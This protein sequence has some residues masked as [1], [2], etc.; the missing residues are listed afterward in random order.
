MNK[1]LY[2][3]SFLMAIL[4]ISVLPS[5]VLAVSTLT[6]NTNKQIYYAGDKLI[7]FGYTDANETLTAEVI[8][9]SGDIIAAE[10]TTADASG[11]YNMSIFAFPEESS[12]IY[13]YGNYTV[14]VESGYYYEHTIIKEV[15]VKYAS[16]FVFSVKNITFT[17]IAG[18]K[19]N[20]ILVNHLILIKADLTNN[21][22]VNYDYTYIV[23]IKDYEGH[24]ISLSFVTG[25]LE[26]G[27]TVEPGVSWK[28]STTGNYIIEIYVWESFISMNPLAEVNRIS[29][30]VSS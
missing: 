13:P 27:E 26:A 12:R 25:V 15:T 20:N 19:I 8:N 3:L 23:Q 11:Y 21:K 5:N 9:P 10:Q 17:N 30:T 29:V 16:S 7:V 14:K 2:L 1:K 28:P 4:L 24:I 18:E 22:D 6:V